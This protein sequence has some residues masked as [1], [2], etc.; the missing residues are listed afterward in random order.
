M[1]SSRVKPPPTLGTLVWTFNKFFHLCCSVTSSANGAGMASDEDDYSIHKLK[2]SQNL[3]DNSTILS[4]GS[5]DFYAVKHEKQQWK[6]SSKEK[7][8]ME[9]LLANLF[10]SVSAVKAAYAQLQM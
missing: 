6:L 10:V 2:L 3:S 9:S 1:E 8:A 5:G 7:E 4:K